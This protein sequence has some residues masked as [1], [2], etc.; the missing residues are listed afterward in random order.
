MANNST[1]FNSQTRGSGGQLRAQIKEF[2]EVLEYMGRSRDPAFLVQY[3]E[4]AGQILEQ[5]I[6]QVVR[7]RDETN[8]LLKERAYVIL[9]WLM[10]QGNRNQKAYAREALQEAMRN[11][12]PH[13]DEALA[14]GEE[15]L[16]IRAAP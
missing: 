15:K 7:S 14:E 10:Q 2:K 6:L 5:E 16:D 4:R 11:E 12:K 8:F 1:L 3:Q 13:V 9:N